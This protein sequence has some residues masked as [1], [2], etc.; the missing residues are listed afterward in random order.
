MSDIARIRTNP[1]SVWWGERPRSA[2][3]R[4]ALCERQHDPL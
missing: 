1:R 2:P 4:D 3:R